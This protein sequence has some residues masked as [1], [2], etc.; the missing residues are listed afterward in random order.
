MAFGLLELFL[1]L[2]NFSLKLE[3][4]KLGVELLHT[5]VLRSSIDGVVLPSELSP[6]GGMTCTSSPALDTVS[7]SDYA[8]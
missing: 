7:P 3:F 5:G 6:L 4:L 8:C 2:V 1:E